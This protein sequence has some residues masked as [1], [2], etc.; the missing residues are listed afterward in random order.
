LDET[1]AR[2]I[3]RLE[4]LDA[5]P[6]VTSVD[7]A[8]LCPNAEITVFPWKEPPELKG[9]HHRPGAQLPEATSDGLISSLDQITSP[10]PVCMR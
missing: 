5:H 10:W 8:S 3:P 2:I 7:V 1:S 6:M 4:V 9:A